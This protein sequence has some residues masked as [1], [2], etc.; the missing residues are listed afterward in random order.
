MTKMKAVVYTQYG[1][2]EVLQLKEVE[3]PAPK[4]NEILVRVKATAVNSGD[5]RLRRADPF[6]VRLFFGLTKP[7]LKILGGVFSGVVEATGKDVTRFRIG[8]EVFGSTDM[9]FGAYAEYKCFPETGSFALK[10]TRMTHAEAAV[11]PFGGAT[12]L[13]FLKK[14]N[15]LSGQKV[16]INGASGAVGSAA[17]QIAKSFGAVV[18]GVCSAANIDLVRSIGADH[19]IAYDVEDFSKSGES[20]DVIYDTVNKLS[21]SGSLSSL[22]KNGT[23]ILGAAG[24][25]EMMQGLWASMTKG[26]RV[27]TGVISQTAEDI[28]FLKKLIEE[29]KLRAVIDR[30]YSLG[31]LAEAH[32]YAEKGHKKGNLSVAIC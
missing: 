2:P 1:P 22:T 13:Y 10:P 9:K 5:W 11:I 26:K 32:T 25:P 29:G 18:T 14:A 24:L 7:K 3:K 30:S 20:Y 6:G 19:V 15:I 16:L 17:V 31:Q 8:D 23:L 27:L 21:V 4:N 28:S 12:A